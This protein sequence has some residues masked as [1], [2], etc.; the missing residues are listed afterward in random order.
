M[1]VNAYGAYAGDKLLEPLQITRRAP[2]AH[3]TDPANDFMA[4]YTGK[5]RALPLGTHLVQVRVANTAEGNVDLHIV[6]ARCAASDLQ[7]FE[8]FVAGIGAISV[9]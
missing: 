7:R 4:W 1:L 3:G 9:D 5:L 6:G 8:E 2:G